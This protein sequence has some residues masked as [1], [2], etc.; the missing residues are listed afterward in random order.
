MVVARHSFHTFY[1]IM[2]NSKGSNYG[3]GKSI[4]KN[5]SQDAKHKKIYYR[6]CVQG[7]K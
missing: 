6:K 1:V 2:Y 5:Y 7:S 4:L 3:M